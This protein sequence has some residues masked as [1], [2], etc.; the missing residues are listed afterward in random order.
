MWPLTQYKPHPDPKPNPTKSDITIQLWHARHLQSQHYHCIPAYQNCTKQFM[1]FPF[2]KM[3]HW[4]AALEMENVCRSCTAILCQTSTHVWYI[5]GCLQ[6]YSA[7][8][9]LI[10]GE[11]IQ[12]AALHWFV[13]FCWSVKNEA[14]SN[15][16]YMTTTMLSLILDPVLEDYTISL[17]WWDLSC[18]QEVY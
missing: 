1:L 2:N 8:N 16:F 3:L 4:Q 6:L 18:P 9:S 7:H 11:L 5:M 17:W 15:G 13:Q 12:F 10:H 14:T